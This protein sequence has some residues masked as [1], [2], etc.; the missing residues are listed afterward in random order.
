MP[1]TLL[2][3][4]RPERR[5][6]PL[7]DT[8][9]PEI[10]RQSR[11]LLCL[12]YDGTLSEIVSEPAL[13]RPVPGALGVVRALA[14]RRDRLDIAIVSGRELGDLRG[15]LP[16]RGV[17]MY[18]AHGLQFLSP[19]GA[20]ELAPGIAECADDFERVR[21][22]LEQHVPATGFAIEDKEIAIALHYR[23]A[24]PAIGAYVR[25]AFA[26]FIAECTVSLTARH[27][28]M[29]VEALPKIAGKAHA[30]RTLIE[31]AGKGVVP[32]YFGDD[33]TDED[34]FAEIGEDGVTVLVGEPRRTAARYCVDS[35]REVVRILT[36]A[37][38]ALG[39]TP[40]K[41]PAR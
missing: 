22:W 13:A 10:V 35:P 39:R 38:S 23:N 32:V 16:L 36:A 6:K 8:L 31:R 19:E 26:A 1:K 14:S 20:C 33:L 12:D 11:T 41:F 5:P 25:D 37:A 4:F 40:A 30:V 15:K 24:P 7:P 17:A 3:L 2:K 21:A 28:K 29:V 34:A 18:G 9:L 27:G